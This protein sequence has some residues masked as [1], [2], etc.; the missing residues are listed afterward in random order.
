MVLEPV[1]LISLEGE[2]MVLLSLCSM[3]LGLRFNAR[4]KHKR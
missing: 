1:K 4:R 2:C 3:F